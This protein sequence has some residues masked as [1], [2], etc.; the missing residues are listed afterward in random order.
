MHYK[1]ALYDILHGTD[2]DSLLSPTFRRDRY[3]PA[4][5]VCQRNH[6]EYTPL[7][8]PCH[9][10][11][12]RLGDR[13]HSSYS[14]NQGQVRTSLAPL[15]HVVL[16]SLEVASTHLRAI[17]FSSLASPSRQ[18]HPRLFKGKCYAISDTIPSPAF[19]K[20]TVVPVETWFLARYDLVVHSGSAIQAV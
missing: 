1:A 2:K 5:G 17:G 7:A 18:G 12:P 11:M 10:T 8:S 20:P 13:G 15:S 4:R 3:V 6:V 19:D 14:R 9:L 16:E